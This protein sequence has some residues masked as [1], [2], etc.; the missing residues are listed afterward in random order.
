MKLGLW[1]IM[2]LGMTG[3]VSV[4]P[5]AG[6]AAARYVIHD[7]SSPALQKKDPIT[8]TLSI[9]DPAATRAFDTSN[10]AVFR[11]A[12]RV[13]YYG[14][15][16]W[17][18]RAPRLVGAA[19][20]RSFENTGRI[21][22]VGNR[23]SLP[24]ADFILQTDIRGFHAIQIDGKMAVETSIF[25]RLTDS[26]SNVYAAKLF[27]KKANIDDDHASSVARQINAN[28]SP[29]IADIIEWTFTQADQVAQ[30]K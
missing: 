4:L 7:V 28:L 10:I 13:E 1:A 18:D 8:W 9:E 15:G 29:M 24:R 27:T 22:G 20:V 16:E 5:E 12:G 3:C 23:V 19:L 21:L 14:S 30:A 11:E 26:H 17:A 2:L 6:P 25:A